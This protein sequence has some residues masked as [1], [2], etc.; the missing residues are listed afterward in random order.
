MIFVD[1]LCLVDRAKDEVR[2]EELG[3]ASKPLD[4]DEDVDDQGN[5]SMGALEACFWMRGLVE[6][7]DNQT[8]DQ[9]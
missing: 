1:S 9:G 2:G 8:S 6:F 7:D 5:F 4:E 3:D